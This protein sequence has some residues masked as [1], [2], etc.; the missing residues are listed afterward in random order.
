M[1]QNCGF[2]LL[3]LNLFKVV[4][5]MSRGVEPRVNPSN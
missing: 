1:I 2:S 3:V 5:T 4:R